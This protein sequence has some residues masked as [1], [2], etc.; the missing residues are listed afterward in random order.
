MMKHQLVSPRYSLF[1]AWKR[2][3]F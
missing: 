2:F 3:M 1:K